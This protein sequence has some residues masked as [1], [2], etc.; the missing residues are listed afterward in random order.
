VQRASVSQPD[1]VLGLPLG[2]QSLT[3]FSFA[4]TADAH[5]TVMQFA[6]SARRGLISGNDELRRWRLNR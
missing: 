5:Q 4:L 6:R 2:F 3:L 1:R